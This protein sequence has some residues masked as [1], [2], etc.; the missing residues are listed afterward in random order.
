[1]N[2]TS[3][4]LTTKRVEALNSIGFVWDNWYH[5]FDELVRYKGS[6]LTSTI[7][8]ENQELRDWIKPQR[9]EYKK[10]QRGKPSA[11]T[12]EGIKKLK[13][14]GFEWQ[15]P[16]ERFECTWSQN[17]DE[18]IQYKEINGNCV[19]PARYNRNPELG[20]WVD[21]Q[22]QE[23]SERSTISSDTRTHRKT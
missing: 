1:M 21:R 5:H 20:G 17:Y 9:L 19:V 3:S 8:D 18:L 10:L 2:G 22:V 13:A 16:R 6:C 12:Q 14:I 4:D 15:D 11:L 7:Y 23:V